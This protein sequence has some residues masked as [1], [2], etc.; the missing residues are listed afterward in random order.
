MVRT[1]LAYLQH[2]LAIWLYQSVLLS[3]QEATVLVLL[4]T[5]SHQPSIVAG[6]MTRLFVQLLTPL[7]AKS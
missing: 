3:S 5:K 4:P 2:L 7:E 6:Y 1:D